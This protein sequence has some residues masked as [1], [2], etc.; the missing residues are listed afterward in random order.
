M[1]NRAHNLT[2]SAQTN[3]PETKAYTGV[4]ANYLTYTST[5]NIS[6][7][8]I[9]ES[10]LSRNYRSDTGKKLNMIWK[11]HKLKL[12]L[13]SFNNE[14]LKD[15]T[16]K[17]TDISTK[18][19]DHKE[20]FKTAYSTIDKNKDY[21]LMLKVSNTMRNKFVDEN[22]TK[23]L[24]RNINSTN[25]DTLTKNN[26]NVLNNNKKIIYTEGNKP[27]SPKYS[28][29][30]SKSNYIKLSNDRHSLNNKSKST[31]NSNCNNYIGI[32]GNKLPMNST[33][34]TSNGVGKPITLDI[35]STKFHGN[36]M[37]LDTNFDHLPKSQ[38]ELNITNQK[39]TLSTS[40]IV[41]NMFFQNKFLFVS[42][43][44]FKNLIDFFLIH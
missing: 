38:R 14:K 36:T 27:D 15:E 31:S 32:G 2:N 4:S 26:L 10:N 7:D 6:R 40:Q 9:N 29:K 30:C 43:F 37:P 41:K 39:E 35:Y 12:Y 17:K 3:K 1:P 18:K 22:Y 20:E 8:A 16:I 23:L 13:N 44:H 11:Q 5:H 42:I 21:D 25:S 28:S 34:L 24:S 19:I 33:T